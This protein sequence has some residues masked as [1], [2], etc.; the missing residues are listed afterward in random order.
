[1]TTDKLKI[2]AKPK[3]SRPALVMSF[4]GW[5]NAG[6]VSTGTTKYLLDKFD[7]FEF[8]HNS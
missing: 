1:M 4:S 8:A 6:D 2:Y 5:M 7:A 3:L